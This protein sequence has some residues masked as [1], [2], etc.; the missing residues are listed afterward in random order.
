[1]NSE[2]KPICLNSKG[3]RNGVEG[4]QPSLNDRVYD[5]DG[6]A[7]ACTTSP[8]FM[9]HYTAV[10][11]RGRYNENGEVEQQVEISNR[12]VANAIT[13]VQKDSMVAEKKFSK[14]KNVDP[15]IYRKMAIESGCELP[16][17]VD[18][19]NVNIR[20]DGTV[21][22]ITTNGSSAKRNNRVMENTLRI[23]KL[24]PK[25]CWRLMGFTDEDFS[26]AEKVNSNT[27]L[28]KQAGNSI[29]VPVLEGIIGSLHACGVL[30]E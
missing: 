4:L 5:S 11:I 19:Q 6:I 21:G 1:M 29:V 17:A 16:C 20:K 8:F 2:I 26:K 22:T 9:P 25:E 23:R 15:N 7:T 3:G 28:Y 10:A 12:E 27:Q 18:E 30:Q 24:T 13:T 14:N